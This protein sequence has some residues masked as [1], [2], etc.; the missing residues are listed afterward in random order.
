VSFVANFVATL[1][2]RYANNLAMTAQPLIKPL[3]KTP[4]RPGR[5]TL[6]ALLGN[7]ETVSNDEGDYDSQVVRVNQA[8]FLYAMSVFDCQE[9]S[10]MAAYGNANVR[11]M[12]IF[13]QSLFGNEARF[14]QWACLR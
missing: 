3:R 10:H 14:P 1:T 6:A 7:M 8:R 13:R 9:D 4:R 12:W 11:K 2:T 5:Q